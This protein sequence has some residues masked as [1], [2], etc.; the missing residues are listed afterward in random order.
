[1]PT[2]ADLLIEGLCRAGVSR[3]FA[4]TSGAANSRVL[5]AAGARGVPAVLASSESA[6]CLMAAV[7]GELTGAPGV[8]VI[9]PAGSLSRA[10]V[11]VR[12]A[13]L[14]RAPLI[15]ITER[16]R[17]TDHAPWPATPGP[18]AHARRVPTSRGMPLSPDRVGHV[19]RFG[20]L[21]KQRLTVEPGSASH[22]TAHAVQ[23]ALTEP[24]G[25]VHLDLT[26][27]MAAA[28]ALPIAA[29][30]SPPGLPAPDPAALDA[31]AGLIRQSVRPV[32]IVG[33]GRRT[34]ED[35]KWLRAFAEALPAPVLTTPKAKGAVPEPHPLSLG[36]FSN[37]ALEDTIVRRAD[38]IIAVGLG[39]MEFESRAW[40]YA[41]PLVHLAR[42]LHPQA[43]FEAAITVLGEPGVIL[44]ELA[45][46]LYG[47][48]RADWDVF[49]LD[50]IKREQRTRLAVVAA[51]LPRQAAGR[52]VAAAGPAGRPAARPGGLPAHRVVEI[53]RELSPAGTIAVTDPGSHAQAVTWFWPAVEPGEFVMGSAAA[54]RPGFALSAGIAAQLLAPERRVICF[55]DMRG[56]A[57]AAAELETTVR[58]RLPLTVV[59]FGGGSP[60]ADHLT[61]PSELA[62]ARYE[63]NDEE[64]TRRA[65]YGAMTGRRPA[66][67]RITGA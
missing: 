30:A 12:Y 1:V 46:R 39:A 38:L 65:I 16:G 4:A 66:V 26:V 21:S 49:E 44:E 41:A 20:L 50:R 9:A 31:A 45:P 43:C 57:R 47:R 52:A 32:V 42:G 51:G 8:A 63:A 35:S 59:I 37:R 64:S 48:T 33:A 56:A 60:S 54:S 17:T 6:G 29:S 5:A 13:R 10:A 55:T 58:L 24:R 3:V 53:A 34:T 27:E 15:V 23:L 25:P 62:L 22:W 61:G 2:V 18:M 36:I 14:D 7:T 11:G 40:S 19:A 67:I 28:H